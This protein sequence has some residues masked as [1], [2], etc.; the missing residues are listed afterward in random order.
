MS[1]LLNKLRTTSK[2]IKKTFVL[3]SSKTGDTRMEDPNMNCSSIAHVFGS[4]GN[5]QGMFQ[6]CTLRSL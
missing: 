3:T 2:K 1:N 4:F 6:T 5:L